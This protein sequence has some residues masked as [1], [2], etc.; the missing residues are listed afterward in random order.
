MKQLR[1]E[2]FSDPQ[3]RRF[4]EDLYFNVILVLDRH[5]QSI[6]KDK[7]ICEV[8]LSKANGDKASLSNT[9]DKSLNDRHSSPV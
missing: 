5:E 9:F 3:N 4:L 8:A 2:D 6:A 7:H 1:N